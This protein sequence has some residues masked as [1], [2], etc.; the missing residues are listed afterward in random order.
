MTNHVLVLLRFPPCAAE[1]TV[2]RDLQTRGLVNLRNDI[3]D[4][5]VVHLRR[6]EDRIDDGF[7]G[8]G[9]VAGK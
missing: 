1:D 8:E 4:G 6:L 5:L 9:D 2:V 3:H 7:I